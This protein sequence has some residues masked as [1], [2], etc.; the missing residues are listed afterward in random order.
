MTSHK[1][2][3]TR[4]TRKKRKRSGSGAGRSAAKKAARRNVARGRKT[5]RVK[6]PRGKVAG[7]GKATS[8]LLTLSEIGRR[9]GISYPTLLRYVRLHLDK[10]PHVGQG[11]TRRYRPAAVSVFRRLRAGSPRGRPSARSAGA[12][13]LAEV[14]ALE[15]RV[16]TL[17]KVLRRTDG[18]LKKLA[19]EL[20][21]PMKL[22]IKRS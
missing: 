12:A 21:R 18:V 16:A 13:S 9:T 19:K 3:A 14:R 6:G 5:G 1:A 10:I 11:R 8:G 17:E 7:R 22:T 15:R 4:S 20:R 2:E